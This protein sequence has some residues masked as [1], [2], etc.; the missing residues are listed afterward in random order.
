MHKVVRNNALLDHSNG[1]FR[2]IN[3]FRLR[4]RGNVEINDIIAKAK[5]GDCLLGIMKKHIKRDIDKC[6]ADGLALEDIIIEKLIS[7]DGASQ[8]VLTDCVDS[9]KGIILPQYDT[10]DLI[11]SDGASECALTDCVDS[12]KGNIL[13]QYDTIDDLSVKYPTPTQDI[14][15]HKSATDAM[16]ILRYYGTIQD[17]PG[18][19]SCGY[20][21]VMLLLRKLNVINNDLSVSQFCQ[22]IF[23]FIQT[24]MKKFVGI[25]NDGSN[26]AVQI[27]GEEDLHQTQLPVGRDL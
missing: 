7:S 21:S 25:T 16:N 11:S 13:S 20:H 12:K 17:V 27:L 9:K 26:C 1:L 4:K 3:R 15:P 22:G 24:N 18:D 14:F 5:E 23:N 6:K 8:S 10:I 19:G 2:S